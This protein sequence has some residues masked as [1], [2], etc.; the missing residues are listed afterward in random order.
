MN[1]IL[2]KIIEERK[3]MY[4]HALEVS[5]LYELESIIENLYAEFIEEFTTTEIIEFFESIELYCLEDSEEEE[6]VYNFNITEFI[7]NL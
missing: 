1:V 3:G 6:E 5:N 4:V 2:N 7:N